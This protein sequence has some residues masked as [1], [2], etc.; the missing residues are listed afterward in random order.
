MQRKKTKYNT[1]ENNKKWLF[2]DKTHLTDYGNK[3]V[4]DFIKS[5]I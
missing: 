1:K 2:V 5:K 4:S 3:I